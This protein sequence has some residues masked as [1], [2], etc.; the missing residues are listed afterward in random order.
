[1]STK[2]YS[3]R[4][5]SDENLS[6]QIGVAKFIFNF[7]SPDSIEFQ[8]FRTSSGIIHRVLENGYGLRNLMWQHP[9]VFPQ[10]NFDTRTDVPV[11]DLE[12]ES[13]ADEIDHMIRSGQYYVKE[14]IAAHLQ[15]GV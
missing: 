6:E 2:L 8:V 12:N 3:F 4:A 7:K 5:S 11:K 10:C 15:N 1:M 14:V 9:E 13:V